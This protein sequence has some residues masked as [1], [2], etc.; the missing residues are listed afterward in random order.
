MAI[1]ESHKSAMFSAPIDPHKELK[2]VSAALR[3]KESKK[4]TWKCVSTTPIDGYS[5]REK[6]K[7]KTNKKRSQISFQVHKRKD[8]YSTENSEGIILQTKSFSI[9]EKQNKSHKDTRP[10]CEIC[11]RLEQNAK[12]CFINLNN[13]D[14]HLPQKESDGF[15]HSL[16]ANFDKNGS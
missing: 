2:E 12:K 11:C 9:T 6:N 5:N 1:P 4:L 8:G 3:T 16:E 10:V 7:I 14:N 13:P 15:I